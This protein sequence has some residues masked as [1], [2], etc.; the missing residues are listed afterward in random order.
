MSA[1]YDRCSEM[2]TLSCDVLVAC[3]SWKYIEKMQ[4]IRHYSS[5]N[6]DLELLSSIDQGCHVRDDD[7]G[8]LKWHRERLSID[9]L[10]SHSFPPRGSHSN[11]M[12]SSF[13]HS[14]T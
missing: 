8:R 3:M 9:S 14:R 10:D 5:G 7:G 1:I 11:S 2:A 13:L 12:N 6:A 4:S